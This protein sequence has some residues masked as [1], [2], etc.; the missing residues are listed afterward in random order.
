M[1][2][3]LCL[4]SCATTQPIPQRGER[5]IDMGNYFVES[6]VGEG[7]QIQIDKS[8]GIVSFTKIKQSIISKM[9]GVIDGSTLIRVFRNEI[10]PQGWHMSE[11]ETADD[12]RNL[13]EKIM[14]EEGVKKGEYN[15]EDVKK[16]ITTINGKKLYFLSYKTTAGTFFGGI[17][18]KGPLRAAEAV[19]Y[20][21][22]SSPN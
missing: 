13:E 17:S 3:L 2:S 12:F 9:A 15:L 1:I 19:L 7:W 21:Y 4:V 20:L 8:K 18:P 10:A 6:P 22:G 5:V 16:G 14:I 11:E